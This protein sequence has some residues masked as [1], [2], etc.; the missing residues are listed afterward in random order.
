[1]RTSPPMLPVSRLPLKTKKEALS[2][3][4]EGLESRGIKARARSAGTTPTSH[5]LNDA[6]PITELRP[7]NY[8]FYDAT[9]V[10]WGVARVDQCALSVLATVVARPD[11][12]RLILDWAAALQGDRAGRLRSLALAWR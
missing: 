2:L 1:M 8:V 10:N 4:V 9:Q 3:T 6:G 7:G 12:R 5:E 11:S